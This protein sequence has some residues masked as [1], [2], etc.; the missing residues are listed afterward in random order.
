MIYPIKEGGANDSGS[1]S[2]FKGLNRTDK[3]QGGEWLDVSDLDTEHYPCLAPR[4]EH[5]DPM[6]LGEGLKIAACAAVIHDDGEYHGFTGVALADDCIDKDGNICKNYCF[7][8]RGERR[9]VG[10]SE[11]TEAPERTALWYYKTTVDNVTSGET[12]EF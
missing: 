3:G 9:S 7:Y 12:D 8:Y 5:S 11:L 1:T 2:T 10:S 6:K 4:R